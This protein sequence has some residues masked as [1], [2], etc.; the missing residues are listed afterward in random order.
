VLNVWATWCRPCRTEMPALERLQQKLG[1]NGLEIV[2]VS[3]DGGDAVVWSS[4]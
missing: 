4:V 3:V 1:N 2:A